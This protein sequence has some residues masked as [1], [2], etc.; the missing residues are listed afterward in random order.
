MS[1]V[2]LV[3]SFTSSHDE[4]I[5]VQIDQIKK[6]KAKI[7]TNEQTCASDSIPRKPNIAAAG[8]GSRGVKAS[9][10]NVAVVTSSFTDAFI[11]VC[12]RRRGKKE[13]KH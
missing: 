9:G 3:H 8:E 12:S 7:V 13:E 2:E 10:I 4:I 6:K 5:E 1:K 11:V